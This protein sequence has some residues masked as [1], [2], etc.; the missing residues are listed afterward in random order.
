[1]SCKWGSRISS[2]LPRCVVDLCGQHVGEG[3]KLYPLLLALARWER[4]FTTWS[5]LIS[6]LFCKKKKAMCPLLLKGAGEQIPHLISVDTSSLMGKE[7]PILGSSSARWR[8]DLQA[9]HYVYMDR[10]EYLMSW[11]TCCCHANLFKSPLNNP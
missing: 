5:I 3:K 1:M 8:S 2:S 11:D 4:R 6:D 7:I 9:S 10:E